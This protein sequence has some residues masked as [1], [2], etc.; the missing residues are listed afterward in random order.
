MALGL[1][2]DDARML[3][4]GHSDKTINDRLNSLRYARVRRGKQNPVKAFFTYG[5]VPDVS[6]SPWY[7]IPLG[8]DIRQIY[9]NGLIEKVNVAFPP[10]F[11]LV[12]YHTWSLTNESSFLLSS[13]TNAHDSF[14]NLPTTLQARQRI[15]R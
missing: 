9:P 3:I 12:R 10:W 4:V 14:P 5:S 6:L 2:Q 7:R 15:L 11:R 1:E 13:R 8:Y